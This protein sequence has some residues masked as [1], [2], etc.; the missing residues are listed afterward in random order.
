M[1][2][3]SLFLFLSPLLA[4]LG[5]DCGASSGGPSGRACMTSSECLAGQR[6]VDNVCVD[7]DSFDAGRDTEPGCE[8]T[9]GDGFGPGCS[10]GD[11]CDP[12]D[13]TQTGREVCDGRDNDCD[14][15]A[16][17]GVLSECGDCNPDCRRGG[18][19]GDDDPFDPEMDESDGVGVDDDGALILDSSRI[20]TNFIWIANTAQGTVSRFNTETFVE[21]G[22]YVTGP[23]DTNDPSRTSVGSL[24]DVYVGNRRGVSMSRI[25]VLGSDCPDTNGDGVITTSTDGTFL[26]WGE[27]DCVLW[28]TDLSAVMPGENL[29][30]AVAAQD[31]EGAD[32]ELRQ[33]VWVG[34]WTSQLIAKLDGE[35]GA[36]LFVTQAPARPYGFAL[37][38]RGN[39][40]VST[41]DAQ[42]IGRVDTN[43]CVDAASCMAA[44][45]D[46]EGAGDACV[47]QT[48]AAPIGGLP[49]GITVDFNQRVWVGGSDI[50]RY[51]PDAAPGSRWQRSNLT[52]SGSSIQVHGIA[53]D[54]VG[55]VWGAAQ[56][57]GVV[58]VDAEAPGTW[59]VVTGT[60][61]TSNKGMAVDADGKVWSITQTN[62][63]VVITPG[64]TIDAATVNGDVARS[65][66]NPYTYSDMTGLQLRLATNPRGFYRHVFEACDM[67]TGPTWEE[68]RFEAETPAGTSVSFRVKTAETREALDDAEWVNVGMTPPDA[69]PLDISSALMGAGIESARFLLLEISL[70]AERMSSTMVITPRVLG[71]DVTHS[72]PPIFG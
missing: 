28:H 56:G 47:K 9:D 42:R 10:I 51:D 62:Q 20:N 24:G 61:G 52:V 65:I 1:R 66:V 37:D 63:A 2:R 53:A 8:D 27:D 31:V 23:S 67:G 36:V 41:R 32:G 25:S 39:L 58:R 3:P 17:N 22:R 64:A 69:S 7:R 30:R 34:G 11:D 35:T 15:V 70:R 55:F 33:F 16:D 21:E 54:A 40:W 43:R 46:G 12:D 71:V 5:C 68:L 49:Y 6:C 59:Q 38:G 60:T 13:P 72:C 50:A 19:G 26:P 57:S 44:T 45:C 18:L 4:V 29:I 14:G 48:V